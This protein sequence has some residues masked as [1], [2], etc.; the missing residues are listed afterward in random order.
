MAFSFITGFGAVLGAEAPGSG[1][2]CERQQ[3]PKLLAGSQI[4][5]MSISKP[6]IE[7]GAGRN[8]PCLQGPHSPREETDVCTEAAG[9]VSGWMGMFPPGAAWGECHQQVTSRLDLGNFGGGENGSEGG[10]FQ[11]GSPV[12][13]G[14]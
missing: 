7:L 1:I 12:D 3:D 6:S 13:V 4:Q 11:R 10:A 5:P 2:Y 9:E 14:G 8:C